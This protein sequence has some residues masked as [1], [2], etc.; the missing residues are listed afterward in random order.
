MLLKSEGMF[1]INEK[2][3]TPPDEGLTQQNMQ[4]FR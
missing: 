4:R 2:L 3:E 1:G